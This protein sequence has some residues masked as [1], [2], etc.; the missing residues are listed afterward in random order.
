MATI[1]LSMFVKLHPHAEKIRKRRRFLKPIRPSRANELWYK[2]ELL[3]IVKLLRRSAER[4]LL[5]ELK[6]LTYGNTGTQKRVGDASPPSIKKQFSAM[7]SEFGGIDSVADRLAKAAVRRN[8]KSVDDGLRSAIKKNVGV[9]I[10]GVFA[11]D[12]QIRNAMHAATQA[13]IDLITS[14]PE[15]YFDKLEKAISESW[16]DGIDY[17]TIAKAVQH[18]GDVTESRAKLIGRDQT[19]KMNGA[20]NRV[21]QTSVGIER[22]VWRT[23]LD[24][25]VRDSHAEKEGQTFSWDDPP[26][27]T[28]N[29]GEDI[30]CRCVGEP[31]FDLDEMEQEIGEQDEDEEQNDEA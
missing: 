2:A 5:P 8:L 16:V 10:S 3:K 13:N 9:D 1:K 29:P 27:D 7:Q 25:R 28:G 21:R 26:D 23:S 17:D 14:I 20:F 11:N 15:Q 24:E 30:D 4:H 18:V 19:S 12:V 6:H 31:V 22:Y